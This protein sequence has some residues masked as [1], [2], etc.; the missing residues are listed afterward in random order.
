MMKNKRRLE[1]LYKQLIKMV[2]WKGVTKGR[3]RQ[4]TSGELI[5]EIIPDVELFISAYNKT[6]VE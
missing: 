6:S 1:I 4:N 2:E 3:L 5:R